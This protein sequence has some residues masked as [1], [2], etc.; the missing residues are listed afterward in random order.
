MNCS[1]GIYSPSTDYLLDTVP[2]VGHLSVNGM[3]VE[4]ALL[5]CTAN[6]RGKEEL[7]WGHLSNV[8]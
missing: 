7:S 1:E 6:D 3:R 2:S 8:N 4:A 5:K